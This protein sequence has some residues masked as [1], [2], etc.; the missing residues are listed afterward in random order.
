LEARKHGEDSSYGGPSKPTAAIEEPSLP[1]LPAS[2]KPLSQSN[3][4]RSSN[5]VRDNLGKLRLLNSQGQEHHRQI[6]DFEQRV[7]ELKEAATAKM[8]EPSQLSSLTPTQANSDSLYLAYDIQNTLRQQNPST[9]E[10]ALSDD[11]EHR[12]R[13]IASKQ[14][15]SAVTDSTAHTYG[16]VS[17][18]SSHPYGLY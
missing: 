13:R 2:S 10:Q 6:P 7:K 12:E 11:E 3:G 4:I 18:L 16:E 9:A 17:L 1:P 5:L 15:H 14:Q 8:D